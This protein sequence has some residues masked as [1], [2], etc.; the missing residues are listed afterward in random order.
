VRQHQGAR[1]CP[2]GRLGGLPPGQVDAPWVPPL[3]EGS[4]SD[5]QVDSGGQLNES[6]TWAGV[7]RIDQRA[8]RAADL[9]HPDR[10]CLDG[11]LH[12]DGT[13]QEWAN[14]LAFGPVEVME[15]SR[16]RF[17]RLTSAIRLQDLVRAPDPITGARRSIDRL[18]RPGRGR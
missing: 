11:V 12:F 4:F 2:S 16:Y 14:F 13:D 9:L 7:P 17:R 15:V 6:I 10:V 8:S 1:R 5:Q 18:G 3:Q